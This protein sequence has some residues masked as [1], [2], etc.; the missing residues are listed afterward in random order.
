MVD[1]EELL[2]RLRSRVRLPPAT[3]AA[4]ESALE[5]GRRAPEEVLHARRAMMATAVITMAQT[6]PVQIQFM[7][8]IITHHN[9]QKKME[10]IVQVDALVASEPL[11][12]AKVV[13]TIVAMY[14]IINMEELGL[15]VLI[16]IKKINALQK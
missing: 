5:G 14:V 2:R 8:L 16:L 4:V 1:S 3:M 7:F 15:N 12:L 13:L 11:I 6:L 10:V 9:A